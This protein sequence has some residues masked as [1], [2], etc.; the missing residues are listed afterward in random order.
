[1]TLQ[2]H[3]LLHEFP[4]HKDT[5]HELKLNNRHFAKLFDEYHEVDHEIH[6]IEEG[7]ETPSDDYLEEKKKKRLSLKDQLYAMITKQIETA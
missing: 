3:D 4:Q 1:M 6:R 7:V 2:K 5:I